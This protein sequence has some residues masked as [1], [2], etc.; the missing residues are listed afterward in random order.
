M[1]IKLRSPLFVCFLNVSITRGAFMI[2]YNNTADFKVEHPRRPDRITD[3]STQTFLLR[4][5]AAARFVHWI[6]IFTH[7]FYFGP[8]QITWA[9]SEG[10]FREVY[11]LFWQRRH[12]D[13]GISACSKYHEK[14]ESC[15]QSVAFRSKNND[16]GSLH[17]AQQDANCLVMWWPVCWTLLEYKLMLSS[18]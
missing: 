2:Y 8:L 17:T 9:T 6:P 7:L 16:N 12:R 10:A 4:Q 3:H 18:L 15:F 5:W 14:Q 13:T 1:V 11:V